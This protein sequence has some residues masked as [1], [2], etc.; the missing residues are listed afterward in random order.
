[1][2]HLVLPFTFLYEK[3]GGSLHLFTWDLA[4]TY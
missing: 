1:M 2:I 3:L 4:S